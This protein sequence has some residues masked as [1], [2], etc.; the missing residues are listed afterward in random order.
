MC[1]II[2][3]SS[4]NH[5]DFSAI[6]LGM[7]QADDRGGHSS[8]ISV[9][10]DENLVVRQV[11]NA[12]M[13]INDKGN[14][15]QIPRNNYSFIGHTRFATQGEKNIENTHPFSFGNVI[16]V[17]NGS[18]D[19]FKQLKNK[20]I[21]QYRADVE[22][23][24]GENWKE[25]LDVDERTD[26]NVNNDSKLLYYLIWKKGLSNVL[27]ELRGSLALVFYKRENGEEYMYFYRHDKPLCY[28]YRGDED[29][30]EMWIG[31]LKKYLDTLGC[32][33]IKN[34]TE[35]AIYKVKNGSII[36]SK[37][38][39]QDIKPKEKRST[40]VDVDEDLEPE[41]ARKKQGTSSSTRT[42]FS[43]NCGYMSG[44]NNEDGKEIRDPIRP[45][46]DKEDSA[47]H[48]SAD[49]FQFCAPKN[50]KG[51]TDR[52]NNLVLYWFSSSN[53]YIVYVETEGETDIDHYDLRQTKQKQDLRSDHPKLADYALEDFGQ[54]EVTIECREDIERKTTD[55]ND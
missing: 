20:Y 1:G 43:P 38:Q 21:Q 14:N 29:D 49:G 18:I 33:N 19:N 11:A 28:G 9:R 34:V 30:K 37:Q 36:T 44:C 26:L 5:L 47:G 10:G 24:C 7:L 35:H 32:K 13:F 51:E 22:E 23:W 12:K 50:A 54:I 2:S 17:H 53:P 40:K 27:E 8:G 6:K 39:P 3:A 16:G 41:R 46:A 42:G 55:K 52:H 4:R 15:V 45:W 31:S 48:E 25:Q